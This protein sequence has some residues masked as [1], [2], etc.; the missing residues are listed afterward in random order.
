VE[1][2]RS[3]FALASNSVDADIAVFHLDGATGGLTL[4]ERCPTG[5]VTM[6]MALTADEQFVYAVTRGSAPA[7]K[8]FSIDSHS[9]H[10]THFQSARINAS[11]AYL[12]IDRAGRY[13]F[14]A[15]YGEHLL[16]VYSVD[17]IDASEGTPLQSISGIEHA[18]AAI[19]S[20]D[21]RF[22]YATS[23]GGDMVVC[24][25]IRSDNQGPPLVPFDHV[26]LDK[27]FGPRHLRFS[28]SGEFLYVL[29]EF[30]ATVAVFRRDRQSGRLSLPSVSPRA[31]PLSNLDDGW[32]RP[33]LS[34]PVQPDPKTLLSLIWAAD[35]QI[36]PDGR[37]VYVSER[38]SSRLLIFRVAANGASLEYSG[39]ISTEEQPRGFKID[40]TGTFLVACGEKSSQLSVY[41]I[42]ANSGE[43]SL[44][45]RCHGG[46]GANWIEIVEQREIT[47][48]AAARQSRTDSKNSRTA[49]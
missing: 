11:L 21:D 24:L 13:L 15:S 22:V 23:L 37:F 2:L 33:S 16:N 30:R 43:L 40:P 32:A 48:P 38:T 10:L 6:P 29:S 17:R 18:H 44:L 20:T 39:C 5:E 49:D 19:V 25:E 9:G 47:K 7:L 28:P 35:I 31:A 46:R 41:G 42:D 27:G 36:R 8:K 4:V 34:N 26:A 12:S 1:P 3:Y 14:G 45:S